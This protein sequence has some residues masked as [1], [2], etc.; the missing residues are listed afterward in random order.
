MTHVR[1]I[2]LKIRACPNYRRRAKIRTA[3]CSQTKNV[4]HDIM[5]VNHRD[6]AGR[7]V[8]TISDRFLKFREHDHKAKI[9]GTTY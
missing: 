8:I 9:L 1:R 4:D 5:I 6:R 7:S 2:V 3:P